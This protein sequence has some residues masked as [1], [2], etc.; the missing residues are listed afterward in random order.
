M[1]AGAEV[2]ICG[3]NAHVNAVCQEFREKGYVC[4]GLIMDLRRR[5]Y[6]EEGFREAMEMLGQRLDILVNAAGVQRRNSS[7]VFTE[8]DWD[9]VLAVN[10]TAPFCS[11][12]AGS[13]TDDKTGKRKDHQHLFYAGLFWRSDRAGLCCQQRRADPVHEN[14]VQRPGGKRH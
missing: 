3:T 9:M 4:H 2:V 12:P 1:E 8:E 7:E 5:A 14:H 11:L 10:L 13:E 6:L